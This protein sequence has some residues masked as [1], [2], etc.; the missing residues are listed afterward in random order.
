MRQAE[1]SLCRRIPKRIIGGLRIRQFKELVELLGYRPR[2]KI[3]GQERCPCGRQVP[4]RPSI[5]NQ[6]GTTEGRRIESSELTGP[7]SITNE[8]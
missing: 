6:D 1:E 5:S 8:A 3:C 7:D 2:R 4:G